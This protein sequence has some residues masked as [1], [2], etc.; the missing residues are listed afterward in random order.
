MSMVAHTRKAVMMSAD[1]P[2]GLWCSYLKKKMVTLVP[3]ARE[4]KV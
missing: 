4:E 3:L 2:E 1:E